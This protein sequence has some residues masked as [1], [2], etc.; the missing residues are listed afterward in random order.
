MFKKATKEQAKL[1]LA[2][3]GPSG[4]GKTFS[5]LN[6]ASSLV[7]AGQ[8]VALLDTERGSASKYAD[9]FDF[10]VV[11]VFDNYHPQRCIEVIEGAAKAGYGALIVDSGT[12]FWNGIGGF[13]ALVDEEAKKTAARGGKFDTFGAW[14]RIDPIYQNLIQ[15]I[16]G[17]PLHVIFTLRAKQAYEK[18]DSSGKTK[19]QKLGMAPQMR[20]D[21]QYEFDVEGMLNIEHQLAIGK[22]RCDALDGRVF[23]KPGRDVADIL[24][25]WL[26]S[27][28]TP[29]DHRP[30]PV[31]TSPA[32][33]RNVDTPTGA[34]QIDESEV[35]II[36]ET[37]ERADGDAELTEARNAATQVRNLLTTEQ[38]TRI[39]DAIKAAQKR[40][41]DRVAA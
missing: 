39:A 15:K 26:N 24:R 16:T 20:D 30:A 40:L 11:E 9:R 31:A 17:A 27:G 4:S 3:H 38:K 33:Q 29:T 34:P 23:D 12:H 13:L 19:I 28:A 8:R 22:T 7:D 5:A 32:P 35:A 25:A 37:I 14:K 2:L 36:L 6:I 41:A 1:R 21:F 10:D 18:D